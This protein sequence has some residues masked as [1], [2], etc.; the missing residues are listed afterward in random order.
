M[1]SQ[2][3]VDWSEC[4]PPP[5]NR[6]C[7]GLAVF[8]LIAHQNLRKPGLPGFHTTGSAIEFGHDEATGHV[9]S[10]ENGVGA[11]SASPKALPLQL[12]P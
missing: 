11:F 4:S 6:P 2:S 12:D 5:D 8:V 9:G 7:Q 3:M 1:N 10:A